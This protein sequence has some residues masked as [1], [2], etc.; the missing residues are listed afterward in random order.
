[1]PRYYTHVWTGTELARDPEGQQ[2]ADLETAC[3]AARRSAHG[4]ICE[5]LEAGSNVID[6]EYRIQDEAGTALA[7]V[8]VS[9]VISGLR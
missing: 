9:A 7:N 4:L 3:E 8:P 5:R 2:F 6:L 1:M